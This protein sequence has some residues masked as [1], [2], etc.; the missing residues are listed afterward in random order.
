[1]NKIFKVVWNAA[2]NC[3]VAVNEVASFAQN[4]GGRVRSSVKRLTR[5]IN[6]LI[7]LNSSGYDLQSVYW[8]RYCNQQL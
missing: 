1:M 8:L 5:I 7:L 4:R 3:W 2:R 6:C